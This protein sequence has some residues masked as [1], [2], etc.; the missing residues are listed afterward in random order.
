MRD[1][2]SDVCFPILMGVGL[3]A[4][5]SSVVIGI[6]AGLEGYQGDK[7]ETVTER[8]TRYEGLVWY[9]QHQDRRQSMA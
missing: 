1:F 5:F 2:F 9:G 8:T 4:A 7:Y 3:V 6:A